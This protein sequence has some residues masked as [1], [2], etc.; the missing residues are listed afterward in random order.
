MIPDWQLPEGVDRG[1]WDYAHSTTLA[2]NYD[3]AL[4]ET[5][6]LQHD[7][8]FCERH[9]P[10]PNHLID[11]GCGTGRLLLP[12]ARRGFSCVGVDLSPEMLT[13]AAR[14]LQAERLPTRLLRANLVDLGM[15]ATETFDSAAC[16][17]STFG[18][19]RGRN[20]REGMLAHV[21][22]I[23]RPGGTFVIHVHNRWF[24]LSSRSGRRWLRANFL[25]ML[26]G[27]AEFGDRTERQHQAIGELTLHHFTRREIIR[28]LHRAGFHIGE[29]CPVSTRPD[30]QL[31]VSWLLSGW[32]AYG[33]LIACHKPNRGHG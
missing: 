1:V 22:R 32:R 25:D 5:P 20:A 10:T 16:L 12:F 28:E 18:M 3:T 29:I 14:K 11:L 17:F 33:Y 6:L 26:R 9:L 31:P 24:A 15:I 21:F 19:I 23:I 7:L 8:A 13:V 2:H 30:G 4:C 27:R